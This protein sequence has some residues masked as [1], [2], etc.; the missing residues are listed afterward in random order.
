MKNVKYISGNKRYNKNT[1]ISKKT[2]IYE[3][4]RTEN[5]GSSDRMRNNC[6]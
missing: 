5:E 6:E 1:Y 4:R 3:N 2:D